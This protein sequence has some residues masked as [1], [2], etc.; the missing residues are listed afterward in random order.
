MSVELV[1]GQNCYF[2]VIEANQM[3]SDN[4]MNS[5]E[6]Y[7]LW[8]NLSDNDKSIIIYRNTQLFENIYLFYC[9][10]K[11]YNSQPM[12][13]PRNINQETVNCP[14]I[15]KLG[16]LLN[17]IKTL[18]RDNSDG[19]SEY[20][21]LINMG[22]EEFR[23]GS[24]ALIKFRSDAKEISNFETIK[25]YDDVYKDIIDKYFYKYILGI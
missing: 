3:I 15:V 13:W 7:I 10:C 6:E 19:E 17:G 14:D 24:G 4:F 22:V 5:E 23:D 18:I 16:I 9:G 21:K 2:D 8:N 25:G 1:V 11:V 12:E 20:N